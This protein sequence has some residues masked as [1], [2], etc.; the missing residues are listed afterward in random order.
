MK[1][2]IKKLASLIVSI[3]ML[4][5]T[6]GF[7]AAEV[8][9]VDQEDCNEGKDQVTAGPGPGLGLEREVRFK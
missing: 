3:I 6:I 7:A 5:S 8:F 4:A 9:I 2:K 1:L